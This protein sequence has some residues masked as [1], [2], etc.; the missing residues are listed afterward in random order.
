M[1]VNE[2]N[3][4][5]IYKILTTPT[6]SLREAS[7]LAH[8]SVWRTARWLKGYDYSYYVGNQKRIGK[9]E[10]VIKHSEKPV[11]SFLDL[12]D[13][14]FVKEFLQRGFT[15]QYLRKALGEARDLL[16]TPHFARNNFYTDNNKI[17]LEL[18]KDSKYMIAL[19][20]GGQSAIPGVIELIHDKIEFEEVT[21]YNFAT[22]W[23]PNGKDGKI[24]I[25]PQISFGRPIIHG[26]GVSTE[27]I[28]D[29]YLGEN[30][31]VD[32]IIDWFKLPK[33]EIQAAI[34]YQYSLTPA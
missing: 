14:L 18:E 7:I 33:N 10:S 4:N 6:Y 2:L 23:F 28:Y 31:N 12:M 1:I 15:L 11:V 9:Q 3:N 32:P 20:T 29:F 5:K 30:K 22:R 16:G 24:V 34:K 26:R 8:V 25:D 13:L 19:L 21:N 27:N 17:V